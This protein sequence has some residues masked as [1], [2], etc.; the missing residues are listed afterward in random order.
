MDHNVSN[1]QSLYETAHD[2][3]SNVVLNGD[4]S[5]DSILYNLNQ[6]IE[7]LKNN[8]KGVDAGIRI[9]EVIRV[10]NAMIAIRNALAKLAV[11]SSKVASNYRDIQIAN[12]AGKETLAVLS[13][14]PKTVL[15]DYSDTA[16]TI[17]INPSAEAGKKLID[18]ANT[19]IE[20]FVGNVKVKYDDIMQN[21][22]AGTG[23][24]AANEAFESFIANA[25]TY[26]QTLSE[27]SENITKALRN[28]TF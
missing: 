24:D 11:D 17:Y 7:N 26:R 3:Y 19:S 5:A 4:N 21:W 18:T 22:T 8:W 1:V 12:G 13:C 25:N 20:T 23:R 15:G 2:L 9:Q 16:D 27:V 10:H 6:G 28:Y 14:E